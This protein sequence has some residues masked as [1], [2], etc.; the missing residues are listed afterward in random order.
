LATTWI[1]IGKG[2][3]LFF[4]SR[5]GGRPVYWRNWQ[6]ICD[7]GWPRGPEPESRWDANGNR[8]DWLQRLGTE[9]QAKT[10][11]QLMYKEEAQVI[12]NNKHRRLHPYKITK[13][14]WDL[15]NRDWVEKQGTSQ[16]NWHQILSR[17]GTCMILNRRFL[18][19]W[20]SDGKWAGTGVSEEMLT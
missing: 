8:T 9:Q 12:L 17:I 7:I 1:V 2:T 16:L 18:K 20:C 4:W 14:R 6:K 13:K 11:T 10:K 15:F 3:R 5:A 19:R